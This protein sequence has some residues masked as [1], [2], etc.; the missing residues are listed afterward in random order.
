MPGNLPKPFF[1]GSRSIIFFFVIL[2]SP[3]LYAGCLISVLQCFLFFCSPNVMLLF[4][5]SLPLFWNNKS[6]FGLFLSLGQPNVCFLFRLSASLLHCPHMLIVF[7][8]R[9][10]LVI[11]GMR[12]PKK[13][14]GGKKKK[15]AQKSPGG[16]LCPQSSWPNHCQEIME[17]P[18]Q[19]QE[20]FCH[21]CHTTWLSLLFEDEVMIV[22]QPLTV[23][24]VNGKLSL[25]PLYPVMLNCQIQVLSF[26]IPCWIRTSCKGLDRLKIQQEESHSSILPTFREFSMSLK[27]SLDSTVKKFPLCIKRLKKELKA[28]TPNCSEKKKL[29]QVV[30]NFCC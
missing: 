23:M 30:N 1:R 29:L 9:L 2:F 27:F 24:P 11:Y 7:C 5:S 15:S 25:S 14:K 12:K 6:L 26:L 28:T 8:L 22:S 10:P 19:K 16:T 18:C 20:G 13:K 21:L 4:I 17:R 3:Y